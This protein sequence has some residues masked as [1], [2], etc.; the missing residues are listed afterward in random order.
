MDKRE[1]KSTCIQK[2]FHKNRSTGRAGLYL[3]EYGC[4]R[5]VEVNARLVYYEDVNSRHVTLNTPLYSPV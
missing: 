5:R 1:Y 4:R 2:Y 3:H